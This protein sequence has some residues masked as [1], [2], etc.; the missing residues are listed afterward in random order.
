MAHKNSRVFREFRK[1]VM[2]V[3]VTAKQIYDA[4]RDDGAD[5]VPVAIPGLEWHNYYSRDQFKIADGITRILFVNGRQPFRIEADTHTSLGGSDSP[6]SQAFWQN[7]RDELC[8]N[9]VTRGIELRSGDKPKN[10]VRKDSALIDPNHADYVLAGRIKRGYS[11]LGQHDR[12]FY[13]DDH[14]TH[15][16]DVRLSVATTPGL[17]AELGNRVLVGWDA[18]QRLDIRR[19]AARSTLA[20]VCRASAEIPI[21]VVDMANEVWG[22]TFD[23]TALEEFRVLSGGLKAMTKQ[24]GAEYA[25]NS[26]SFP[27]L[28]GA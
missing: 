22:T 25:I 21:S 20:H 4:V 17:D 26:A 13:L 6:W 14:S 28:V 9:G 11:S 5:I 3:P 23:P 19:A 12:E 16:D 1:T 2:D 7:Q 24:F 8:V 15:L 18:V 10:G 27:E